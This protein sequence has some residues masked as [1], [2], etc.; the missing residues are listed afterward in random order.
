MFIHKPLKPS[1][2]SLMKTQQISVGNST[3]WWRKLMV[4][5]TK[6]ENWHLRIH[7]CDQNERDSSQEST[8]IDTQRL[9]LKLSLHFRLVYWSHFISIFLFFVSFK[10]LYSFLLLLIDRFCVW[11]KRFEEWNCKVNCWMFRDKFGHIR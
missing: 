4:D 9:V 6:A 3:Q 8:F 1:W 5:H 11:G 10:Y 2:T 7:W